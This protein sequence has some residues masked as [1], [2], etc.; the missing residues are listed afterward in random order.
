MD[1]FAEGDLVL[2]NKG[3]R[4][5]AVLSAGEAQQASLPA[6]VP[7]SALLGALGMPGFT[8][9]FGLTEIAPVAAGETV[10]ISAA[11]G[12]GRERR[13]ADRARRAAAG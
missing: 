7:P 3:W 11:A 6:G 2:H 12:R 10:F 4:E 8:A 9:W 13:R 5:V 1:G